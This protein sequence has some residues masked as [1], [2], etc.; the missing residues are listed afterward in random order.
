VLL[1]LRGVALSAPSGEEPNFDRLKPWLRRVLQTVM[2]TPSLTLV[3]VNFPREPQGLI[4]TRV[5]VRHYDGHIV[6]TKDPQGRD[7]FWFSV[8]PIQEAEEGTDR[9]AVEQGW[10]SLTPLRLDLT[11][12]KQLGEVRAHVPLDEERAAALSP[13]T[14]SR[15]A[16]EMVRDDESAASMTSSKPVSH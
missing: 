11:D 10:I 4:W 7:F 1:G 9:W 15:E 12:E 2:T 3:N 5:S 14:S 8:V 16:A 6:P 13:P